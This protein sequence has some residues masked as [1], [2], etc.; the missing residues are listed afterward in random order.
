MPLC[1]HCGSD[2]TRRHRTLLQ[3]FAYSDSFECRKCRS[4]RR[5]LHR[6]FRVNATVL[7]SRY[8][9]CVRCGTARVHRSAKADRIDSVSKHVFSMVQHL[10]GA[11]VYRCIA[12]RLQYYDWRPP[13][14]RPPAG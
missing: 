9:H 6:F 14:P 12:C 11:P 5:V 2:L 7:F 13:S 3:K 10:S 1:P 4:R 8:T